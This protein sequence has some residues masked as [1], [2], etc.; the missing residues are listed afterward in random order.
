MVPAIS[1]TETELNQETVA[2]ISVSEINQ[3][4][5]F[6]ISESNTV[7]EMVKVVKISSPR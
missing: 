6:P 2:A 7:P 1:E 5:F 3:D 4:K